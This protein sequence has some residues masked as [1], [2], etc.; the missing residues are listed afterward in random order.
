VDSKITVE[1]LQ[2]LAGNAA[3]LTLN[4]YWVPT[5]IRGE[6]KIGC[7]CFQDE[8][9]LRPGTQE[10]IDQIVEPRTSACPPTR[11]TPKDQLRPGSVET[12]YMGQQANRE[13]LINWDEIPAILEKD[14]F[15]HVITDGGAR[16]N[17]GNAG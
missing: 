10:D 9:E 13:K 14:K 16:P 11:P 1:K 7:L 2:R 15:V 17:P 6:G 5:V 12:N 8:I 3:H 4:G